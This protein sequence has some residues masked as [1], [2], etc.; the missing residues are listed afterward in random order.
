MSGNTFGARAWTDGKEIAPMLPEPPAVVKCHHCAECYWLEDAE[1][2]GTDDLMKKEG[3]QCNPAWAKAAEVQE[4][5][6]EEYYEALEK[7]L[8]VNTMQERNLRVLAWW[9]SNDAFRDAAAGKTQEYR[10]IPGPCR[11]N[12]E[13][14]VSLLATKD[15]M[16]R[17][18]KAEV[19]REL[20]EFEAAKEVLSYVDST[21]FEAVVRQFRSLCENRDTCVRELHFSA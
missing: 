18:M 3:Q 7:G 9:R 6:E 8:A 21:E 12:L 10:D 19:L 5:T 4:P 11:K 20:G 13:A 16:D 17:L 15:D 1:K 2:V 14:L